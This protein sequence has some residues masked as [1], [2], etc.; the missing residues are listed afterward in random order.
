[1]FNNSD[2]PWALDDY[3]LLTLSTIAAVWLIGGTGYIL[4]HQSNKSIDEDTINTA[5]SD[6]M[7]LEIQHHTVDLKQSFYLESL[8]IQ[9]SYSYSSENERPLFLR[10]DYEP[11]L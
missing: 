7:C 3:V 10:V 1:M 6:D 5:Q 4:N 2:D 8:D 11:N 9:P